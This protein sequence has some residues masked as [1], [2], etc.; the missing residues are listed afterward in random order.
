[1]RV[2]PFEAK[3]TTNKFS[4][5][6]KDI[7][8]KFNIGKNK[9]HLV[10]RDNAANMAA[11]ITQAD[12]ESLP[13]FLHTLQLILNEVIFEQRY[14]KDVIAVCKQ[15]V[16]HFHHSPSAFAK[17]EEYQRLFNVPAHRFVQDVLT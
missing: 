1:M 17:Y 12:L 3:H 9:A 2:P 10:V 15:I 14:V 16:G 7:L 11:G 5:N 13:C 4:E 8:D 6:I